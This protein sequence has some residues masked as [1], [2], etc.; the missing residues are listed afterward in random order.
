MEATMTFSRSA[1]PLFF[2][3]VSHDDLKWTVNYK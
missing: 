2:K 3:G 1:T